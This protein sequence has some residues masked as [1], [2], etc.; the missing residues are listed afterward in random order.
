MAV[1][2]VNAKSMQEEP[3]RRKDREVKDINEI[4]GIIDQCDI[5]RIG[6]ADGIYIL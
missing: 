1:F 3:M 5:V 6:L 2:V 4:I